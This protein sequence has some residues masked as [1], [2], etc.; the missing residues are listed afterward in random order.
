MPQHRD[1]DSVEA[2]KQ[3]P[4][5]VQLPASKT[6]D[7]ATI[8]SGALDRLLSLACTSL[9]TH[10]QLDASLLSSQLAYRQPVANA[11]L[12]QLAAC[13]PETRAPSVVRQTSLNHF[14]GTYSTFFLSL[15]K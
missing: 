14:G 2:A 12:D 13:A 10:A 4:P 11:P 7:L 1:E 9:E 6:P 3:P 5:P 15:L 8:C